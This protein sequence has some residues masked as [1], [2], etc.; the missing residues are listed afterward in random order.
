MK[1]SVITPMYN[2]FSYMKRYFLS[3]DKQIFRDFELIIVDDYSTDGSYDKLQEYAAGS[4]LKIRSYRLKQNEGPG[5]ARNLGMDVAD[6]DWLI[7][8]DS[9]DWV[10]DDILIQMNKYIDRQNPD[11]VVYDYCSTDGQNDIRTIRGLFGYSEGFVTSRDMIAYGIA[12]HIKCLKKSLINEKSIRY[13][14]MKRAEDMVFWICVFAKNSEMRIYYAAKTFYYALQRRHSLSRAV[15]KDSV[16]IPALQML[17]R[18]IGE[19]MQAELNVMSIRMILYGEV[20]MMCQSKKTKKEISA[21]LALYEKFN[22]GWYIN[23]CIRR[24]NGTKRIFLKLIHCRCYLLMRL[25]ARFH[26]VA[27]FRA[28]F[29]KKKKMADGFLPAW[30]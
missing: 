27:G 12:G 8:V 2:S 13:P 4:K 24:F 20:L 21:F 17:T 29:G 7:F 9:D 22:P 19:E 5:I 10:T 15:Y 3:F 6:G 1:Y 28:G 25:F 30:K 11:C 18:Q 14:A 23:P 26:F 16:M